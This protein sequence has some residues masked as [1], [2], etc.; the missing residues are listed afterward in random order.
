MGKYF[1]TDGVRG[2][3]NRDLTMDMAVRIGQY[4]GWHARQNSDTPRVLIGQDTRLSGDMFANAL[5]AG[6]TSTGAD[7]WLL[8]VC[9][10]PAISRLVQTGGFDAGIMVSA[11]HNPYTDNGIKVFN[12][13]GNKMEEDVLLEIEKYMDGEISLP[14]AVDDQIGTVRIWPQGLQEYIRWLQETVPVDLNG[15]KIAVDL[16]NGSATS[17]AVETLEGLGATV[18]A[19]HDTPDGLNINYHAGS[20]HPEALQ[21]FVV[22]NSC[23]AGLAFDGDA[24]RLIAVDENGHLMNGDYLIYI[25]AQDM[26]AKGHLPEKAVVTT[27]MANLGLYKALERL[28][29]NSIQ[30]PVGDKYVFEEM[31]KHGYNIGGEQSGHIIF[32]EDERTGDG[33][34]TALHLLHTMV[35]SGKTLSELSEGLTIYPQAL[36]NVRVYDKQVVLDDEDVKAS[37][38]EVERELE[39]NGRVLVRPSGTEPLIR[40]MVEAP[41]QEQCDEACQKVC[42]VIVEKGYAREQ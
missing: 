14:L 8:G 7:A 41:T 17:T 16:A 20:T 4:L 29:Y 37:I 42:D 11:S 10:T 24:D 6:A 15:V 28:Q 36:H 31:D 23:N 3:A 21:E 27:V 35:D 5:A 19:V 33:L 18:L 2:E 1:G 22:A 38:E 32:L 12:H 13:A 39:G 9:P 25:L 26:E 34:M 40:V 30:T